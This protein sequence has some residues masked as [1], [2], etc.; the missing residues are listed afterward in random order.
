[1]KPTARPGALAAPDRPDAERPS[2]E[3]PLPER[4]WAR[5]AGESLRALEVDPGSGLGEAEAARRLT[6]HGPNRLRAHRTRGLLEIAVA[7]F[8][9]VIVLLLAVAAVVSFAFASHVEAA[10][11]VAVL[12]INALIGFFTELRAVK[13][14]EGL[15]ELA[16]VP[17][18]VRREGELKRISAR[19]LVPGDLLVL[20]G[21]D[22]VTAD[23]RLVEASRLQV[24]ESA[25]TGESVPVEKDEA[26]VPTDVQLAERASMLYKGTA[27]T[28]GSA[29]GVV[30]ATGM[31]TELG[32]VSALVEDAAGDEETPLERRLATM[33]RRLVWVTLGLAGVVVASGL[34][35]G[36]EP[37]LVVETAI[38]LAVAAIPEGLPI[39][40]TL[41]LARG[42]WRMAR[43]NALVERL[44]AVETLGSTTLILTDKTGTLT[45]NRMR[46]ARIGLAA[47]D[48]D[49]RAGEGDAGTPEGQTGVRAEAE[50][51][52][53]EPP[54]RDSRARRTAFRMD[55]EPVDPGSR[56]D[57]EALLRTGVLC[58][59]ATLPDP[60]AESPPPGDPMETALLEAGAAGGLR[61]EELVAEWP[62]VEREAFDP[63]AKMMA[64]FHRVE[65]GILVAVK[66]APE[67]V[68][69]A[70]DRIREDDGER[71]LSEAERETWLDRSEAMAG[72]G[73]RILAMAERRVGEMPG[74]PYEQLV[75][76]GV[77]GLLDP[78]REDVHAAIE[79]CREAG[80][81][82]V[83]VTGDHPATARNVAAAVG[84]EAE[85]VVARASPEQKLRLLDRH[86][87]EGEVVAMIGDGVNDAPALE[88]ADIGVAMGQ[89]GTQVAR[90]A[91]EMIL[92][93]DRFAT[94]VTAVEQGRAIF[95]N[96]RKFVVYLLSCN[97]SEILVVTLATLAGAPLPLL[98][99][100]ILFL[101]LVT[102]VF[103]ALA[104][105]GLEGSSDLMGRP[106]RDPR[107]DV[108]TASHWRAVAAYGGLLTV[109]VL[110]GFWLALGP[111][112]LE[113]AG[114]VTISFL[115][116]ALGQLW[117]VFNMAEPDSGVLRNEVTRSRL[118][119]GAVLLCVGLILAA[120]HVPVLS[121]VLELVPPGRREW[122]V[123]LG[124]SL[125]PLAAGRL[126]AAA[127]R[128]GSR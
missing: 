71:T 126:Y 73:F 10:A 18:T 42:M 24:D 12:V 84:I 122:A 111:L 51:I 47:G 77:V 70:C 102:D 28:R 74:T 22:V 79:A 61:R 41:A 101:N 83:M 117:H 128:P 89:R 76:L 115:I 44:S 2:P 94:I 107:E 8:R 81:R 31:E 67:A 35:V 43:R 34:A 91:A 37:L 53:D 45:E 127:R 33:G 38:A 104:L 4:P 23:L 30:V 124:L 56:P 85:D 120:L 106:P 93:D 7:Q 16:D 1:M 97:A 82:V 123:V 92:Q 58:N 63:D 66:G 75:L 20:E 5:P 36:K 57:L 19:E 96:I 50:E 3:R 9:S 69:E 60:D 99:L 87:R 109:A 95:S 55:G 121:R 113:G 65:D 90:E 62:E 119:W 32:H 21:G 116:L 72:D 54:T 88:K 68:L 59:S 100:Q 29:V 125:V 39:V 6:R 114:P 103:P 25:L 64:T 13:S 78:P 112:G 86:Q 26:P 52:G 40:A 80:V 15:R 46:V 14:M 27:V 108:L 110:A 48:V 17:A 11:I 118:V 98:P 49:V 105:G